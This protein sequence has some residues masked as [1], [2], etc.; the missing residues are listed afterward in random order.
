[1]ELR[2]SM[3]LAAAV[4]GTAVTGRP[5]VQV[6]RKVLPMR[7]GWNREPLKY[8]T[9]LVYDGDNR[10][11]EEVRILAGAARKDLPRFFLC[12]QAIINVGGNSRTIHLDDPII[13][14]NTLDEAF[15]KY[16]GAL[17]AALGKAQKRV[18]AEVDKF[19]EEKAKAE[20]AAAE[21]S[22]EQP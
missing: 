18:D 6:S 5:V 7:A 12:C 2:D 1:M 4:V 14:A 16:E 15:Q 17:K 22:N 19:M 21:K 13:G 9:R 20:K 3:K 8:T 10:C 11:V